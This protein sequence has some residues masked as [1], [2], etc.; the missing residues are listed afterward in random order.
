MNSTAPDFRK[1]LEQSLDLFKQKHPAQASVADKMLHFLR[2]TPGCFERSH[3][4]GH[5]TGSAWLVNPAGD[6]A[7]LT[8]HRKLGRWMQTGG[9]ADGDSNLLQVALREATEESGIDGISPLDEEIF[10]I[11]I[12]AIPARPA[13][14][15]AAHLHYDVRYLLCSPHEQFRIS[16]ESDA[17]VWW[18]CNGL[19]VHHTELDEAVIRMQRR[20]FGG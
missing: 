13:T 17:L 9:H 1:K 7:L 16:D 15:E 6:K 14:G 2:S 11:D 18:S 20:Y 8:L 5:F 3:K 4:E 19:E 12:H 10:D